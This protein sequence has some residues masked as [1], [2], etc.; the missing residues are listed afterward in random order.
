MVLDPLF[1]RRRKSNQ[2]RRHRQG[3]GSTPRFMESRYDFADVLCEHEPDLYKSLN[4]E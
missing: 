4:D 1:H 3:A 2:V